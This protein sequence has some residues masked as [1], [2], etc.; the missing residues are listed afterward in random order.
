MSA[1]ARLVLPLCAT[2]AASAADP[3][4]P[5][6]GTGLRGDY[7]AAAGLTGAALV[8]LDA[9]VSFDWGLGSP[10]AGIPVDGF[11]ARWTGRIEPRYGEAYT[12]TTIADDGVRLWI[13]GTL[14]IDDWTTHAAAAR[15]G[16]IALAAGRVYDLRLEYLET[17][18]AASVSL[19]W[20]SASQAREVVPQR[21]LYP[22]AG[23]PAP[24]AGDGRTVARALVHA[25]SYRTYRLHV[26]ASYVRGLATP[27]VVANHFLWANSSTME[28]LTGFSAM[29]D[30]KGFVV[31]YPD[32]IDGLWDVGFGSTYDDVGFVAHMLDEL[33]ATYTVDADRVFA[34]GMSNGAQFTYVLGQRLGA[35]F[36]AIAPVSGSIFTL[37]G[38]KPTSP[39]SV[40]A[41]HGTADTIVPYQGIAGVMFS[42]EQAVGM[43]AAF[44]GCAPA[45]FALL[46]DLAP[47]DGCRVVRATCARGAGG[48]EVV[49]DA[50]IGGGHAWPGQAA[51]LFGATCRDLDATTDIWEFFAKHPR[52]ARTSA[53]TAGEAQ[54]QPLAIAAEQATVDD[55]VPDA[56]AGTAHGHGCGLGAGTGLVGVLLAFARRRSVAGAGTPGS[57]PSP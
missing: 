37:A 25:G 11:S 48:T 41:M 2:V 52:Q 49:L 29:A 56:D 13:D 47:T 16:T 22:A 17:T 1:I 46:P 5:G 55:A 35:R 23:I 39:V 43:W 36:A 34:T 38:F 8:R 44:D 40:L 57:R 28:A 3:T 6:T 15:S 26:P 4:P 31:A 20:S 18:G 45:S 33:A 30:R 24:A 51:V 14:V 27:V 19:S 32:A 54:A 21:Q 42:E 7:F 50:I 9:T 53:L 12:F 10:A